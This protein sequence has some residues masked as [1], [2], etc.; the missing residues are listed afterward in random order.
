MSQE[1]LSSIVSTSIIFSIVLFL[2]MLTSSA[3]ESKI[4]Q[5]SWLDDERKTVTIAMFYLTGGGAGNDALLN[6]GFR[7]PRKSFSYLWKEKTG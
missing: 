3:T 7:L 5:R 1:K 2:S 4:F 6:I